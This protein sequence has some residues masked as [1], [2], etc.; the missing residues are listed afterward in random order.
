MILFVHHM[1]WVTF[2]PLFMNV[3]K[4]VSLDRPMI[5]SPLYIRLLKSVF[6]HR[7]YRNWMK[8]DPEEI[9]DQYLPKCY[10][11]LCKLVVA[12]YKTKLFIRINNKI[13]PYPAFV[14]ILKDFFLHG[15]FRNQIKWN[16]EGAFNYIIN[17][18]VNV[19]IMIVKWFLCRAKLRYLLGW[20]WN[21]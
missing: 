12:V 10:S 16:S 8:Y 3:L 15:S 4:F 17:L 6:L 21:Y 20:I 13:K 14:A 18:C 5:Y 2:Q 7:L 9:C 11:N 1:L 19:T